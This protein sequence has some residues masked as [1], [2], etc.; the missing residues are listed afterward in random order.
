VALL[1]TLSVYPRIS[2]SML[3]FC[4]IVLNAFQRISSDSGVIAA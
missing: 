2:T 1:P 3:G 4:A